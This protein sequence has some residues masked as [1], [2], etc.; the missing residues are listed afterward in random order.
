MALSERWQS[1]L[2]TAT[3]MAALGS[4]RLVVATIPFNWWSGTLGGTGLKGTADRADVEA[5]RLAAHV[6]WAARLLPFSTKCLP[7]AMAL[8]WMLRSRGVGH[9][10]VFAARP[11]ERRGS[12]D[13]LHAWVEVGGE[14]IIGDLPGPWIEILAARV[15]RSA[16]KV[17]PSYCRLATVALLEH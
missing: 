15:S 7:R 3:A 10:L 5:R 14:R 13:Q 9:I 11:L 12:D 17:I 4:A 8:S 6:E 1:R 2:R 16:R